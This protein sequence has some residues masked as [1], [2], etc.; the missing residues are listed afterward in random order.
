MRNR[1][2]FIVM[3]IFLLFIFLTFFISYSDNAASYTVVGESHI[4]T[5]TTWNSS[6]GPYY[7][8]GNVTV[9]F[10]RNLT[11]EAGVD[12][13]FNG[14]YS[15][16]VEGDLYALGS[17]VDMITFTTNITS[18][19]W[20]RIQVNAT[21]YAEI[22]YCR[23][24]NATYGVC[25]NTSQ[26]SVVQ[27]NNISHNFIGVF[28]DTSPNNTISNNNILFNED[29]GIYLVESK[30]NII[31][32]N[33]V[34]N[35]KW[36]GIQLYTGSDQNILRCN[37]IS[38]N[39]W[40]GLNLYQ[41][42][43]NTIFDNDIIMNDHRGIQAFQSS[44]N[45]IRYN[46]IISNFV[47]GIKLQQ[48]H[49][50]V[51]TNNNISY[52]G[53]TED[54]YGIY[55]TSSNNN[56]IFHNTLIDNVNQSYDDRATNHWD[57]GYPYGGNFWSDYTGE[58]NKKGKNQDVPGSD[59]I[60]DSNYTIDSDS[61]D[62]YPLIN[63]SRDIA[64]FL[65]SLD[66]PLNNSY[67]N[68]GMEIIFDI[69]VKNILEVNYSLN[70]G[71]N[72]TINPYNDTYN[73]TASGS[74]GWVEGENIIDIF[75]WDFNGNLNS[76]WFSFI[77]DSTKPILELISP[78]NGSIIDTKG[79]IDIFIVEPNINSASYRINNESWE[80]LLFP[81]D[82]NC[83]TWP[84]GNYWIDIYVDDLSGNDNS[85]FYT[86]TV[87]T[88]PPLIS[89]IRPYNNSY[90]KSGV[91]INLTIS[92][93]HLNSS[94]IYYTV[95]GGGPMTFTTPY[96]IDTSPWD[97]GEY[98]IEIF[99]YDTLG[100]EGFRSYNITVDS[101]PPSAEL[102]SPV[103]NSVIRAGIPINFSASDDNPFTFIYSI[104]I[105]SSN[106]LPA[107][108]NI[109]TTLFYDGIKRINVNVSDFAGNYN[110]LWFMFTIDSTDPVITLLY[111]H[112]GSIIKSGTDIEIDV[113]ELNIEFVNYSINGGNFSDLSSSMIIETI[114]WIAG[115][116][117]VEIFAI[118][119]SENNVTANFTFYVDNTPPQIASSKPA[120]D[121]KG[122]PVDSTIEITFNE[123]MEKASFGN[124]I[125]IDPPINFTINWSADNLTL[126]ITPIGNFSNV[127]KY[128]VI[129]NANVTDIA[130]NPMVADFVLK[131]T[132]GPSEEFPIW[133][134]FIIVVAVIIV[135]ILL[136]MLIARRRKKIADVEKEEEEDEF[137]DVGKEE[138]EEISE[139]AESEEITGED[140]KQKKE[141]E[142]EA[143]ASEHKANDDKVSKDEVNKEDEGGEQL[144]V[145]EAEQEK[146]L[147]KK[148]G[149]GLEK[150]P[151]NTN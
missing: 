64:P 69:L 137:K 1:I 37:N 122:V 56:E 130:G 19:K 115:Y 24:T 138:G 15:I 145:K 3:G 68:E 140:E 8:E 71:I 112:N 110:E 150:E 139:E 9:D 149:L 136:I 17:P 21:G 23:I 83:S 99:A 82:L 90:I 2:N 147:G 57:D 119:K 36:I 151:D 88:T 133:M 107:P 86:F 94:S 52:N 134:M 40:S 29:K 65:I 111:P 96:I 113:M 18:Q 75:V 108:Y 47:D 128:I 141:K 7:I 45:E 129:I 4:T 59:G 92:D 67:L 27:Y 34:T 39:D 49:N 89:L 73:I 84:E 79:V 38:N 53:F 78:S 43:N 127:T 60:G 106:V 131:F 120:Q 132:T 20:N 117:T 46:R 77:F 116:N 123:L 66:S 13:Y 63:I 143:S 146:E 44:G 54:N 32:N 6:A 16:Y 121:K 76:S 5:N 55:L 109:N 80:S 51:V 91:K 12:I 85:T 61:I 41:T 74:L 72:I 93:M 142:E 95:S 28:L 50:N 25:L 125:T 101:I 118:D 97:D 33:N 148:K 103:N 98:S 102:N 105:G 42:L 87:D 14:P 81:Y 104:N 26:E 114:D 48:S 144:P 100:H 11:I 70:G 31:E 35:G 22:K 30:E 62:H 126:I 58:D 10:G 124:A 135:I